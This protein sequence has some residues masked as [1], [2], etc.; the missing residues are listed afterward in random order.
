LINIFI[1]IAFARSQHPVIYILIILLQTIFLCICVN[2][3][4]KTRW[5]SYI[6][7]LIFLGGLIVL[8]IYITRLASNEKFIYSSD[9]KFMFSLSLRLTL[10]LLILNINN[11]L[12]IKSIPEPLVLFKEMYHLEVLFL[13]SL[14]IIYLLLT[15]IVVIKITSK[16][17]GPIRGIIE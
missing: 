11:Q 16:Y 13:T 10:L 4:I 7:F 14:S 12:T 5:F 17:R 6:L 3:V 1:P 15:L 9:R 2:L 8:F